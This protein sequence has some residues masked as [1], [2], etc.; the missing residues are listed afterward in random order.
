MA[1]PTSVTTPYESGPGGAA[2]L[3]AR[4][5]SQLLGR[6]Y[7]YRTLLA[8][9]LLAVPAFVLTPAGR[10]PDWPHE[11][12]LNVILDL[13]F[14][15]AGFGP[16]WAALR[17]PSAQRP[18]W[19]CLSVG[20]AGVI[21]GTAAQCRALFLPPHHGAFP[22]IVEAGFL[23]F[24]V[25]ALPAMALLPARDEGRF[26]RRRLLDGLIV[27]AAVT[28]ISWTTALGAAVHS[29]GLGLPAFVVSLAFPALDIAVVTMAILS[30]GSPRKQGAL[31]LI[32]LG[33]ILISVADSL[34]GYL[35][36]TYGTLNKDYQLMYAL[37]TV[38]IL[39]IAMASQFP[40][41]AMDRRDKALIAA[42][43]SMDWSP[44]I[45]LVIA[46]AVLAWRVF[47]GHPA[48]NVTRILV[49]SMFGL[50]IARQF[51]ALRA[52]RHL[53][54][55]VALRTEALEAQA[56]ELNRMR[57]AAEAATQAKTEFLANMSHEIRTPM[58]GV[59]GMNALLLGTDL[60][61]EQ[62]RFS[63]AVMTSA[64]GLLGIINDILDVSK[65]EAGKVDLEI[66]DFSLE[67]VIEEVVELLSAKA[68]EKGLEIGC[69]V[70]ELARTPLRGDPTRLRQVFLNLLFNAI[71]FTERGFVS[72]EAT[73]EPG[74]DGSVLLRIEVR[75]SGIGLTPEAKAKLF[76]KFQQ[77]DG[78]TT[79]RFGG[80]GLGLS[81]CRQLIEL[82]DGRIDV[83]DREGGGSIFWIEL[84]M[85]T[86]SV[87]VSPSADAPDGRGLGG[88]RI[89]MLSEG[90]LNRGLLTRW[91]EAQGALV[92]GASGGEA[93]LE[94][95]TRSAA[96]GA[97]YDIVVV[98]PIAPGSLAGEV[99]DIIRH[100]AER[101]RP[102]LVL[103]TY[104]HG[105][106]NAVEAAFDAIVTRP[107]R[108]RATLDRLAR[109]IESRPDQDAAPAIR[110]PAT[111]A[112]RRG[113]VLLVEDHPINTLLA[114]TLLENA[115]FHVECATNGAE[116]IE[117]VRLRPFDLILM[118][119]QMPVMGGLEATRL[120]RA[121]GPIQAAM[122]LMAMTA[123]AM[124]SD[125]EA[126]LAAGMNGHIAKPINPSSLIAT[127]N[128]VLSRDEGADARP[129][130]GAAPAGAP[131]LDPAPLTSLF[132][133]MPPVGFA[134]LIDTY[135]RDTTQ[136]AARIESLAAARDLTGLGGEAH[137]MRGVAG[138]FGAMELH[139]LAGKL[140]AACS[141]GDRDA[142]ALAARMGEAVERSLILIESLASDLTGASATG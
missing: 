79:R 118:D 1:Y 3:A 99:A 122:P 7:W 53:L 81:I 75:D 95:L 2:R 130:A 28:S 5:V 74:P 66:I 47:T 111:A 38:G 140:E 11:F 80:T 15:L 29:A 83:R 32:C 6:R 78:S 139:A 46:A 98:D 36:L 124:A 16:V 33:M 136:R 135:R 44:Y 40:L 58:N 55:T 123:N 121:M 50:I 117:A 34:L 91:L 51:E 112:A 101:A 88:R 132:K 59:I 60:T 82:M 96:E 43:S 104:A 20:L 30:L 45:P 114:R 25:M 68:F 27:A 125:Q 4:I 86:A 67:T 113:M 106:A 77:A 137:Q 127:L 108:R 73:A 85:R 90:A 56:V 69:H 94:A 31:Y 63:E 84:P 14:L 87:A 19:I 76:N 102:R 110:P 35:Q 64:N 9:T 71:K 22:S 41:A 134:N 105:G 48:N 8:I 142:V 138:N 72:I 42:G 131:A 119:M 115:G 18:T 120:I 62:R 57:I 89:L 97:P 10:G 17:G 107:L 21:G 70:D 13:V 141:A 52:N 126:C 128:E 129:R 100:R 116:A 109:L 93:C 12:Q 26:S 103:I 39:F 24:P 23:L 54:T 65:L 49:L 92:D 37:Y 133:I 61:P